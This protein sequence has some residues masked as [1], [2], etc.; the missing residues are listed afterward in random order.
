M[1]S[2]QGPKNSMVLTSNTATVSPTRSLY[3]LVKISLR[4]FVCSAI[5]G[6]NG[7]LVVYSYSPFM[8]FPTQFTN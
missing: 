5:G 3:G 6:S 2:I 4:V 1:S 8:W 7:P